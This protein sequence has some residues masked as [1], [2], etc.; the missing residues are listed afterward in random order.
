MFLSSLQPSATYTTHHDHGVSIAK[1]AIETELSY[2]A[3]VDTR[4]V[5]VEQS[6]DSY[7]LNGVVR[8]S[9]DL[10]RILRVVQEVVGFDRI[11]SRLLVCRSAA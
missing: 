11:M 9:S 1:T 10:A 7:V 6:G 5:S 2:L 4:N 8:S 3:N